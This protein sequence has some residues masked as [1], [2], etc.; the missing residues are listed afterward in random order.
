MHDF[1]RPDSLHQFHAKEVG[2]VLTTGFMFRSSRSLYKLWRNVSRSSSVCV[3]VHSPDSPRYSLSWILWTFGRSVVMVWS[4]TPKRRSD[5]IA[6]QS[7][8]KCKH[9]RHI[10]T[11]RS[12][13][14]VRFRRIASCMASSNLTSH[15]HDS[16]SIILENTHGS[17]PD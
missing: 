15:G 11:D 1:M 5:P 8:P 17:G 2:P 6:T 4:W 9:Y 12:A 13:F 3:S 16:R 14:L 10:Q 7:L